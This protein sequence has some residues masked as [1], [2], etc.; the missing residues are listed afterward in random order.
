[1][2]PRV[3]PSLRDVHPRELKSVVREIPTLPVIYQQL[4]QMMQDPDVTIAAV[5]ELISHDQAL[6]SKILHLVNSAFYKQQRQ[7]STISRALIV[8]GFRAV[9][10]AALALS[11]FDQ[12]KDEQ[13]TAGYSLGQFWQHSVASAS[14]CKVL[15]EKTLPQHQEE[16][17]IAGLLHDVGKLVEKR[18]FPN[19]F[20]AIVNRLL[21]EPSTWMEAERELF[22]VNHASIG[23]AVFRAWD[24]PDPVVESIQLHHVPGEGGAYPQ[25]TALVHLGNILSYQLN[26]GSPLGQPPGGCSDG[27]LQVLG[28]DLDQAISFEPAFREEIERALEILQLTG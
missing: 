8:L 25:L 7:I 3:A 18:Y 24:F 1:M 6:T 13:S 27:C 14:I 19:D 17:F 5:G 20:D 22:P 9:R 23:R 12:F 28:L 15:A 26:M 21:E 4:F 11:I 16:A 10:N 2:A